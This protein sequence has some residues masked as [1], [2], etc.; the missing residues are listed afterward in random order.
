[1]KNYVLEGVTSGV[2]SMS[3]VKP[4]IEMTREDFRIKV[5]EDPSNKVMSFN[6]DKRNICN[7]VYENNE[8]RKI[9]TNELGYNELISV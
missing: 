3:S 2:A 7:V 1:M 4:N 6:F 5:N 9:T 8:L